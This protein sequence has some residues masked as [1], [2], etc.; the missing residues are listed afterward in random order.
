[1]DAL[2]FHPLTGQEVSTSNSNN[3]GQFTPIM[4]LRYFNLTF[5]LAYLYSQL[6]L[7]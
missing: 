1:M 4:M 5:T 3:G 2:C 7:I 6:S